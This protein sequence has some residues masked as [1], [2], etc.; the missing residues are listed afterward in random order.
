M[1]KTLSYGGGPSVR[2]LKFTPTSYPH[3]DPPLEW[4]G[5]IENSIEGFAGAES[6]P[7]QIDL[8]YPHVH[9]IAQ[10]EDGERRPSV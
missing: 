2:F 5:K 6:L 7:L 3:P 8:D 4:G 1:G 9:S 10:F